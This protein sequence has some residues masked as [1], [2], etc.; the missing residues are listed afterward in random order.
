MDW[1]LCYRDDETSDFIIL[2]QDGTGDPFCL[3]T[4]Q[5]NEH[6]ECAVTKVNHETW[7]THGVIASSLDR[8]LWFVLSEMQGYL[9]PDGQFKDEDELEESEYDD[10]RSW[11]NDPDY[12][13]QHDPDI[14]TFH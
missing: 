12:C 4:H 7:E 13:L 5:R 14:A 9:R 3:L 6:G 2:I 11:Y 1:S 10:D 8:L